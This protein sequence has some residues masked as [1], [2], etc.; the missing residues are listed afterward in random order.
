MPLFASVFL[1]AGCANGFELT[2]GAVT[3]GFGHLASDSESSE[4]RKIRG[5]FGFTLGEKWDIAIG[6]H[7]QGFSEGGGSIEE[8]MLGITVGFAISPSFI[9]GA[10]HDCNWLSL[11]EV[12]EFH[13]FG[14]EAKFDLGNETAVSAYVGH[15]QA[16]DVGSE[17]IRIMGV[18]GDKKFSDGLSLSAFFQRDTFEDSQISRVG[19]GVGY[20]LSETN[21]LPIILEGEIANYSSDGFYED[22]TEI[23]VHATYLIGKSRPAPTGFLGNHSVLANFPA[24]G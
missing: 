10:F 11:S 5:D 20:D 8:T 18:R 15:Y 13:A 22:H 21:N 16:G 7:N 17:D 23:R 2:G 1:S 6:T 3:L 4:V 9:V 12:F 19:L 14:G 24:G